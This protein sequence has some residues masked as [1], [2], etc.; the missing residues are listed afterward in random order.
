[1]FPEWHDKVTSITKVGL[2]NMVGGTWAS[3]MFTK[4]ILENNQH[5]TGSKR[6][7]KGKKRN[8][9]KSDKTGSKT[10]GK[11]TTTINPEKKETQ[12]QQT[13]I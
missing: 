10:K 4:F 7:T 1:M 8:S 5:E 9:G 2:P 11:N 3:L 13:Q 6:G 12:Q